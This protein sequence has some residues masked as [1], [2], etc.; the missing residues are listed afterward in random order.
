M[1]I[2]KDRNAVN[3]QGLSKDIG[4]YLAS[5]IISVFPQVPVFSRI[6]SFSMRLRG[7]VV[8][9]R[10]KILPGVW[11]DRFDKLNIGDD[12]SLARNVVIVGAGGIEIGDRCMVGYSAKIL[13]MDHVIP[14]GQKSMRF[15][16]AKL[17][18]VRIDEDVWVGANVVIKAGVVIGKGAIV[19]A[20]AVVVTDVPPFAIVGGVPARIIRM[21]K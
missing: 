17:K 15:A 8:G 7:A 13:S 16:G 11:I 1:D 2:L 20:G 21:R 12:V 5:T 18:P 10:I 6:K 14:S 19:G 3:P 4:D 9:Q